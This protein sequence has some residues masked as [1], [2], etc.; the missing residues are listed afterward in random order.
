MIKPEV[1]LK[2]KDQVALEEEMARNLEA[3]LQAE[4]IE[5]DRLARKKEE[6]DNIALIKSWENTQAMMEAD[7]LLA[8]RLQ[9]REQ[10]ELTDEEKDF[11]ALRAQEK[12]NRP[13]TKTQKR[14]QMSIYLKHMGGYKHNQLKGRSYDEIQKLFDKEMKRVNS[15][16]AMNLET[17]EIS[18]KK[19]ESSSKKA[20]IT[21]DSSAKRAWDK[22]ESDK[23]KKQ[24]TD[25]NEEVEVDNKA[26]LKMHMVTVKDDDIAIDAIP[27]ATKPPMIVEYKLIREGIMRHYQLI[28]TDGSSKRYSS[29]IRMLQGIDR[30]DLQTLWKLDK[31]KHGDTRPEDE[32][33]RVF[34]S[35]VD[36]KACWMTSDGKKVKCSLPFRYWERHWLFPRGGLLLDLHLYKGNSKVVPHVKQHRSIQ[37][38]SIQLLLDQYGNVFNEDNWWTRLKVFT[39]SEKNKF[40]VIGCDD[41]AL[42]TGQERDHYSS[43]CF[44]LCSNLSNVPAGECSGKGCCQTSITKGLQFYNVTLNSF[45]NHKDVWSINRC[46]LAFLGE[47]NNF[48]FGGDSD[49]NNSA[50]L[51]QRVE[52][53]VL[54]VIDWV[55]GRDRNCAQATECKDNSE[56]YDVDS[57]G[58][59]CRCN[60]GYEGN[61]YLDPG[62]QDKVV[63]C[64]SFGVV[65]AE[66]LTV[67]N[68]H[69]QYGRD[70]K[71]YAL[72]S[73][74]RILNMVPTKKVDKIPYE[75]WYGKVPNQSYLKEMMGYYFYFPP[76]NKIVVA[77]YSEFFEKNLI[78]Q[79]VSGRDMDLEEI[80]DKDTSPSEIT[81]KIPMEVEGF[82]PP[83]E[84]EIPIR[85]SERT[86]RTSNRLCLNVEA[87]EHKIQSMMENMVW[88][89]VDLPPGYKNV[90]SFVDPNHPR[91]VCKLQRSIYGLKQASRSWNKRFDEEIK[92]FG[93][94][95]NLDEPCVYQKASGS[96]VTFLILYVDDIIIMGNHIPSLQS[97]KDYLGKCF[98]MK[99]LGE[100][101]FILGIKIYRDRSKR[102]IGLC[103]NAYMDKI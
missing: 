27:L 19:Y 88:V 17:Q 37:H 56:C 73:A 45:Q 16:M 31:T 33:E 12:R 38:R 20:E 102:L 95:Q 1:P 79:E 62:C 52:S 66:L 28:R 103:Q 64:Y 14:N 100:A 35:N 99:D 57:G 50:D 43:G 4:L 87:E 74:T 94:A 36:D 8:E 42:I 67:G 13:P 60:Q 89:L 77:R 47:E 9:T 39:F 76:E 86:R 41:S 69:P 61:P 30:E 80:K 2:K 23:S 40:T 65:L 75:L 91:K 24:K 51:I 10:E 93:F 78:T 21:Q 59:R 96:N 46:G 55:I 71:D 44:G 29:I 11:A 49:L 68:N 83:Q 26:E 98:A 3:Q 82:E 15:F 5:E 72:K 34:L 90:G 25:E 32:H 22:L 18:G 85:R 6:E 92:R 48:E 54:V 84:E 58:Y 7:R 63:L 101:A 53:S 97:V 70:I 81:S